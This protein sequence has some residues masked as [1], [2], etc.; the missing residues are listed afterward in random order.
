VSFKLSNIYVKINFSLNS[1]STWESKVFA[2]VFT[3]F[4]SSRFIEAQEQHIL[5]HMH[6]KPY[7]GTKFENWTKFSHELYSYLHSIER[8]LI[9]VCF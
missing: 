2:F 5:V 6:F 4:M 3:Q 1:I 7:R 9:W 8:V